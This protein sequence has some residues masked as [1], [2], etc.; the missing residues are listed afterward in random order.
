[1]IDK[2]EKH[3]KAW[4]RMTDT[5]ER[6]LKK[7]QRKYRT[8]ATRMEK[9][10]IMLLQKTGAKPSKIDWTASGGRATKVVADPLTVK[11]GITGGPP[12]ERILGWNT[13]FPKAEIRAHLLHHSLHGPGTKKNLTPTSRTINR[14]MLDKAEAPALKAL[15]IRPR[16]KNLDHTEL[17]YTTTVTYGKQNK[18]EALSRFF[19]F[20]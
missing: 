4:K 12:K 7:K 11:S 18:G 19:P 3:I 16:N 13:D 17:V 9:I 15:G 1:M 2:L 10:W 14:A 8:I 5:P 6:Q 20:V